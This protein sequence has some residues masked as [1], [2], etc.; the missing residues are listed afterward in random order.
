MTMD[1]VLQS[2]YEEDEDDKP[3][4]RKPKKRASPS[5]SPPFPLAPPLLHPVRRLVTFTGLQ[6]TGLAS[7]EH[8]LWVV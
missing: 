7:V 1:V 5:A 4:K 2:D 3:K 6:V 8:A